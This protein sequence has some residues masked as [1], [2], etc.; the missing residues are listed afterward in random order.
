LAAE[1]VVTPNAGA[2]EKNLAFAR[3]ALAET[4]IEAREEAAL[5]EAV[6]G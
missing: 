5:P 3:E 1:K 4:G 2:V 6:S